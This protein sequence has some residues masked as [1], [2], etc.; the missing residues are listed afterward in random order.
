MITPLRGEAARSSPNPRGRIVQFRT[1]ETTEAV[2]TSCHDHLAVRKQRHCVFGASAV[3]VAR[4]I[5][6]RARQAVAARQFR[7]RVLLCGS[8]AKSKWDHDNGYE[9]QQVKGASDEVR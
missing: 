9:E 4:S 6:G 8:L 1:C 5:P 2:K 7:D 3:K